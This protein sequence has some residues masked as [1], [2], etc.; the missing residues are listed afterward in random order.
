MPTPAA[1]ETL[2]HLPRLVDLPP[3][4]RDALPP[5]KLT[6]HVF[7]ADAAARFVLVDGQRLA[8]GERLSPTLTLREIRR[9]GAVFESDGRR[10]LVPR[11]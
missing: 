3:G 6:M 11:L 10:F 1:E 7:A 5:L 9:D 4:E 8:Q 2:E